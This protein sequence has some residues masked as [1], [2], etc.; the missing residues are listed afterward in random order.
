MYLTAYDKC[1]FY[2]LDL[3]DLWINVNEIE[4]PLPLKNIILKQHTKPH[5]DKLIV[6]KHIIYH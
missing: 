2:A 5:V 1:L 4:F 3:R 6:K